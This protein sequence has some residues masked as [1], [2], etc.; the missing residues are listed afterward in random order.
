MIFVQGL[1][2]TSKAFVSL[3]PAFR[4]MDRSLKEAALTSGASTR[5]LFRRAMIPLL[6]PAVL[7]A[8][9]FILIVG[10][11]VFEIPGTLGMPARILTLSSQLFHLANEVPGGMPLCGQVGALATLFLLL[12]LGL[13]V[14]Y[15]H[16]TREASRYRTVT[17]KGFRASGARSTAALARGDANTSAAATSAVRRCSMDDF[18]QSKLQGRSW[19]Q[20]RCAGRAAPSPLLD[21]SH[22]RSPIDRRLAHGGCRGADAA[23]VTAA[24]DA[25]HGN[26]RQ[27]AP[28][29]GA[30]R[31]CGLETIT[32]R[33][34]HARGRAGL[35]EPP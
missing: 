9:V 26:R 25:G 17:G 13:G 5:M 20:D 16:F 14:L 29:G 1:A 6:R 12:L 18:H 8:G 21:L 11:V 35:S 30:E 27:R 33:G 10:F 23:R 2:L 32:R 22:A 34:A 3:A 4:N 31:H 28:D 7:A 15:R 24:A 19:R